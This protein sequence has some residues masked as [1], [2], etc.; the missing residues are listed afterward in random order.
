MGHWFPQ[1]IST[2]GADVDHVFNVIYYIVGA[3]FVAAEILFFYFIIRYRRRSGEHAGYV[4]GDSWSQLAWVL[5]PAAIV[6]ALDLGIDSM[7]APVWARIKEHRPEGGLLIQGTA[8]QFNW[9]FTYAGPDGK[10][11]TD[12]DKDIENE[13]HVPVG[14]DILV[15][16]QSKDV[17]HSFYIPTVRLKQDIMPGRT[18]KVWFNA[19]VPGRYEIPCAQLCGFG[20]YTMRGFLVVHTP[21]DYQKWIAE[22]WSP[23]AGA[24]S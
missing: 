15:D 6:L 14:R 7:S 23:A 3:W 22:T 4:R 17:I 19:T 8:K 1:N 13:L 5:V 2:Y 20:H 11:G 16:L 24:A 12:D 10:F 18:T 9:S 21:E